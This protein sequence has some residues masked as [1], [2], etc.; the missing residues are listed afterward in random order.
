MS[1]TRSAIEDVLPLS[2]LQQGLLFHATFDEHD[3][4]AVDVYVAQLV[5]DV[6]G[7]LDLDRMRAAV[8]ELTARHPVLRTAIVRDFGDPV[9]V[10]LREV[11]VP[12]T[13]VDLSGRADARAE[14]DRLVQRDRLD[15]FTLDT[16]PLI[17]FTAIA[18]GPEHHRLVLTNHHIISDGWSTPLLMRDLFA[19]YAAGGRSTAPELPASRPYRDYLAWLQQQDDTASLRAWTSALEGVEEPTLLAPSAHGGSPALPE[20]VVEALP[21]GLVSELRGLAQRLGVTLNTVLQVGWGLLVGQLTGGGDVVFGTTVSGRPPDLPGVESMVGLFIN[22]VP[23]RVRVRP[24]EPVSGLLSRV[25]AEQVSLM[26]HHHVG[27]AAIQSALGAGRGELFDSL[28]VFE[29]FPFG[30]ES[31]NE[32]QR[33]AGLRCTSVERPIATHYPLTLMAMPTG[34]SLELTLKYRPDAYDAGEARTLLDRL[35]VV[36]EGIAADPDAPAGAVDVLAG[37]RRAELLSAGRAEPVDVPARTLPELFADQVRRTPDAVAVVSGQDELTYAELDARANSLAQRLTRAGIGPEDRVALLVPRSADLVVAVLGVLK[38]GAAYVPIDPDHPADRIRFVL[39][40]AAPAALVAGGDLAELPDVRVPL[41]HVTAPSSADDSPAGAPQVA[42]PDVDQPAYVIY[43]SGSTGTPKGVVVS[44]RNVVGLFAATESLFQFG[45]EDVWTL[46]HSYA[47]DFSVWELWGPLLH[48]GRLVVVPREVTR[49]PADFLRLLAEHRVTVLNQTPSAFE[50]LSRADADAPGTALALRVVVFGGEALEP[51]RLASWY[52]RHGD[53]TP[54]LVN[55]YGITETTVHVSYLALDGSHATS[56]ASAIGRGLPGLSTYLLDEALR[57]V[58]DGVVG[59]LYVGGAQL[60]R[61]Y[62]GRPGLTATRFVADPFGAPGERLYRTGDLARRAGDGRLE[63]VGRAD[64]QVKIR[65]FRI[66]PAEIS[67]VLATHPDVSRCAVVARH[68]AQGGAYLVVYVVGESVD[69]AALRGYLAARLP[70]HMVPAAFVELE[71]LPLTGNGKLD[72]R[73]LP[74]PEFGST[75][76]SREPATD[77]ERVLAELFADV[78]GRDEGTPVGVDESFFSLGGHSLLATRLVSRIRSRLGQEIGVRAVFD[79]PTVAGLARVVE[80]TDTDLRPSPQSADRRP[81][82]LPLSFAQQ[83]LWFLYCFDGPTPNYNIPFALRISGELDVPALRKALGDVVERHESLRTVIASDDEGPYQCILDPAECR[84][85][86]PMGEVGSE[87]QLTAVL[88]EEARYPF[89]LDRDLPIRCRLWRLAD[90]QHVLTVVLHHIAGDGWS[91]DVLLDDLSVAYRARRTNREPEWSPLSVQYADYALW[92]RDLLGSDDDPD[93]LGATQIRYWQEALE[94]LGEELALPADRPRPRQPS[95]RG[96][97]VRG[98]LDATTAA[99]LRALSAELGASEFMVAQAAVAVTLAKLGAGSDV[100]LGAPIAG[101]TDESL[102]GLVG[103]F[104]NTLVVRND[105]SGNPTL[106][107]VAGRTRDVVLAGLEHQDVPFERLVEVLNPERTPSRHPLF[108]V[109]VVHETAPERGSP[110]RARRASART[111][112]GDRQVRPVVPVPR[113]T[114]PLRPGRRDRLQHRPVRRGHGRVDADP[115]AA[116]AR[117]HG[118]SSRYAHRSRGRVERRRAPPAAPGVQRHRCACSGDHAAGA[119]RRAGSPHARRGRRGRRRNPAD[120]RRA[121][122]PCGS[123]GRAV[124]RARHGAGADRGPAP[125]PLARTRR[126]AAGGPALRGGVRAGGA[127]PAGRAGRRAV[128]DL[129]HSARADDAGRTCRPARAGRGRRARRRRGRGSG[130][131][132]G[133]AR[134][135]AAVDRGQPG[136]RHLHLGNHR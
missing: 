83:R 133:R 86:V 52:E 121:G 44:H 135:P 31:I 88:A 115:A 113:R 95:Y 89:E 26:D 130:R 54:L 129:G 75:A 132:T 20:E 77:T 63:Y 73:A 15:R 69:P 36:L 84:P 23:V 35:V 41:F 134:G 45:P 21:D 22:T 46:F 127:V 57:P 128:P 16:A 37:D 62:L 65:G 48:G 125:G 109:M 106:R 107:E 71:S 87:E 9:Q 59:E 19:L 100:P 131:T 32:A 78:L 119:V 91:T 25:Q 123:L 5:L 6:E 67:S 118:H 58:P 99:G 43:T 47:F 42:P 93:S 64:D 8:T 29:S 51:T 14:A 55:M 120:L 90:D 80:G 40:D 68:G 101:R 94:G 12:W 114:R 2:P 111:G 81:T 122:H 27:L 96:D 66:E 136:L 126:R 50:E 33:A 92:Q 3:P 124:G 70:E 108:Q 116:G 76:P 74:A 17:R 97:L 39:G 13:S 112:P 18:L 105:V 61:G 1:T 98:S 30:T 49:S 28:V 34:D 103:F 79:H 102:S 24:G 10:V 38:S 11:E 60:A 4:D 110:G 7:P 72:R 104:V 117:G 82:R 53:S 56:P 85:E